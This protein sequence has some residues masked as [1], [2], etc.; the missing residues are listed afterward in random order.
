[1]AAAGKGGKTRP[2][3]YPRPPQLQ[4]PYGSSPYGNPWIDVC[5]GGQC[6][7]ISSGRQTA[8]TVNI[9]GIN[10]RCRKHPDN[11][12]TDGN[13]LAHFSAPSRVDVTCW[14]PSSPGTTGYQAMQNP[15]FSS[16]QWSAAIQGRDLGFLRTRTGC[17]ISVAEVNEQYNNYQRSMN[18]CR[19]ASKNKHWIGTMQPQYARKDCY[20]CPSLGCPSQDLGS[21]PFVDLECWTMGDTVRGS[22]L[23]IKNKEKNCYF[24]G[25]IFDDRGWAGTTGQ[26]CSGR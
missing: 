4:N 19:I 3:G 23:W 8:V 2:G 13:N 16:G 10:I 24:P 6:G 17:Y 7:G 15:F 1:M 14:T 12:I 25:R 11:F 18:Q 20:A 26:M 21:V 5:R 22:P 9:K